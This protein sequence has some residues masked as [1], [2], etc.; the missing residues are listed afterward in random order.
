MS[1]RRGATNEDIGTTTN[2]SSS[3]AGTSQSSAQQT[4]V[5]LTEP[6]YI[7]ETE[8]V[9]K[10][11]SPTIYEEQNTPAA[12]NISKTAPP[13][14]ITQ[15]TTQ[16]TYE[17]LELS[18]KPTTY[19]SAET[20]QDLSSSS[21]FS[22]VVVSSPVN[23]TVSET[24]NIPVEKPVFAAADYLTEESKTV[25]NDPNFYLAYLQMQGSLL[26]LIASSE[27]DPNKKKEYEKYANLFSSLPNDVS[28]FIKGVMAG[29]RNAVV[30]SPIFQG[31]VRLLELKNYADPQVYNQIIQTY[32]LSGYESTMQK[33]LLSLGMANAQMGQY[34]GSFS[35][36]V[37]DIAILSGI[38]AFYREMGDITKYNPKSVGYQAKAYGV[39][40]YPY[41]FSVCTDQTCKSDADYYMKVLDYILKYG[42]APPLN[43]NAK[44]TADLK[45]FFSS[46]DVFSKSG[47]WLTDSI[48]SA[49]EKLGLSKSTAQTIASGLS[50]AILGAAATGSII[51]TG[52]LAAPVV[53]SLFAASVLNALSQAGYYFQ[54]D[55]EAQLFMNSFKENLPAFLA[56]L[57][58]SLAAA[59]AIGAA[60][61]SALI[62]SRVQDYVN[63]N[64]GS[65]L[66]RISESLRAKG[67]TS[68]AD[69][70]QSFAQAK[71]PS[72]T[73]YAI[74]PG[75]PSGDFT[76]L[77][78]QSKGQIVIKY[79][80]QGSLEKTQSVPLP[81]NE[82]AIFS[83]SPDLSVKVLT[84]YLSLKKP[85]DAEIKGIISDFADVLQNA[86]NA[87]IA[88]DDALKFLDSLLSSGK[89]VTLTENMFFAKTTDGKIFLVSPES[90]EGLDTAY[91][92]SPDKKT[93]FGSVNDASGT[94]KNTSKVV[95][96][97][98]DNNNKVIQFT[99]DRT[100]YD[101]S[102][103]FQALKSYGFT[104]DFSNINTIL[105]NISQG[106]VVPNADGSM[107]LY[108]TKDGNL[109][110]LN[111]EKMQVGD[112]TKMTD[113]QLA[114]YLSS[115]SEQT[116]DF[117]KYGIYLGKIDMD[118][119]KAAA[120]ELSKL[121]PDL[122]SI[123]FKVASANY[124]ATVPNVS[125]PAATADQ[126]TLASVQNLFENIKTSWT[127]SGG[128]SE[129]IQD[130]KTGKF[131]SISYAQSNLGVDQGTIRSMAVKLITGDT[132]TGS[133][134][135]QNVYLFKLPQDLLLDLSD[136][137]QSKFIET[138][139]IT[140][141]V[142]KID[143]SVKAG[144]LD[145]ATGNM[146]KQVIA[147]KTLMGDK[148]ADTI[149]LATPA[150]ASGAY[151]GGSA[152]VGFALYQ[153]SQPLT[154]EQISKQTGKSEEEIQASIS[155]LIQQGLIKP[156]II[157]KEKA[158][159]VATEQISK[160]V[161]TYPEYILVE[162][163]T[164]QA[165]RNKINLYPRIRV[166]PMLMYESSAEEIS[167]TVPLYSI[168]TLEA[169]LGVSKELKPSV[170]LAPQLSFEQET[171]EKSFAPPVQIEATGFDT[172]TVTK[173]AA[174]VF[175][176]LYIDVNTNPTP[177]PTPPPPTPVTPVP[178]P[179][180]GMPSLSVV[181]LNFGGS[182]G[183]IKTMKEILEI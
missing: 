86:K 7:A 35:P 182:S 80:Y 173:S 99:V 143:S 93:V 122:Q 98:L 119:V 63:K 65:F 147:L 52:G 175:I 47:Q 134:N 149:T 32:G 78:D 36:T 44:L 77:V 37:E 167:K 83:D 73:T 9:V 76:V 17:V 168:E 104:K 131:V 19:L 82:L 118:G 129:T 156:I 72:G 108:I 92:V 21:S 33:L 109:Y 81:S 121:P 97:T 55:Y 162:E 94:S 166:E 165:L 101:Y 88:V 15:P 25:F 117:S 16:T 13:I 120:A 128:M 153:T 96:S 46:I 113:E 28:S 151:A 39:Y 34:G 54:N 64:M 27:S 24:V 66:G 155:S 157:Q 148:G 56:G 40:S 135:V 116:P 67:Y 177:T 176:D 138:E 38:S 12:V 14:I 133:V 141:L 6:V 11:V 111:L 31:Y 152:V 179:P 126:S 30:S 59:G 79:G 145:Q 154:T 4:T 140:S 169:D 150:E 51:L 132:K 124:K 74:K 75:E 48:S 137:I 8:Q 20:Q 123:L 2:T 158:I 144:S 53:G 85:S 125:L 127:K 26:N 84:K 103:L 146:L 61:D 170:L 43:P 22:P 163:A 10:T 69:R 62:A 49:L 60:A 139:K 70:I 161:G 89:P 58:G 91:F 106:K 3:S 102:P 90:V 178:V 50:G 29:D 71:M 1:F 180:L 171:V 115:I 107:G 114:R 130:P 164:E 42:K 5:S 160:V 159:E 112:I 172:L 181:P 183:F 41:P 95:I 87:G 136:V 18:T 68:L 105:S 100:T 110:I 45:N 142:Q 57:A 174:A 23:T